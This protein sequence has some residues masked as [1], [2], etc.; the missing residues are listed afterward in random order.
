M[1]PICTILGVAL[2]AAACDADLPKVTLSG[3]STEI[4]SLVGE[5]DGSYE[6]EAAPF[7]SGSIVF[8][9]QASP[10]SASGNVVTFVRSTPP[11]RPWE[12]QIQGPDEVPQSIGIRLVNVTK[13]TINGL[14]DPYIDPSC[15]CTVR[16]TFSGKLNKDVIEGL[17]TIHHQDG[18][19][20][21]GVWRMK[22]SK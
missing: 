2:L 13:G 11:K 3:D 7:R 18:S 6:M 20:A 9:I 22:R 12:R 21:T 10:D 15:G 17:F 1:R 8:R 19:I 4:A 5:W 16:T 14:L